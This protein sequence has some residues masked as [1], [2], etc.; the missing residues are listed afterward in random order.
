MKRLIAGAFAAALLGGCASYDGGYYAG[1]PYYS[2]YGSGYG[3]Y[4]DHGPGYAPYYYYGPSVGGGV[5]YYDRHYDRYYDRDGRVY[6]DGRDGRGYDRRYRDQTARPAGSWT[7]RVIPGGST[8]PQV[9]S[10]RTPGIGRN[11]NDR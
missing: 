9:A 6:G 1:S 4:Y 8:D 11:E 3:T 10:G 7:D 5:V 2:Y